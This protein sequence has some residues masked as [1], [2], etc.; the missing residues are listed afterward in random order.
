MKGLTKG[1]RNKWAVLLIVPLIWLLI[2]LLLRSKPVLTPQLIAHRGGGGLAPENTL[3]ALRAGLAAGAH[4]IEVDVQR[5]VDG[6]IVL[7]HDATVDET[8]NGRG[9]VADLTWAEL[10][11]L[12][13]G[14]HFSSEFAGEA[15]PR[16]EDALGLLTAEPVTLMIEVKDP[17]LYPGL[18]SD[19]WDVIRRAGA[20]DRVMVISFAHNWIIG[21]H[22]LAPEVPIGILSYWP[23]QVPGV[24]HG[25][26]ISVL[27]SSV[28]LDPTLVSRVHE[29]G[30]SIV[31]FTVNNPT[32]MRCLL[33]LGIDGVITDRPDLWPQ[34][35][36]E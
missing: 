33:W 8:T 21:F 16:L 30:A 3:A 11:Q 14:S 18:A 35:F 13:A 2:H 5:S 6:V 7:M 9:R 4:V 36:K 27:W 34:A 28:L 10:N 19:L 24:A 1:L 25:Q 12:D 32:L 20:Q 23:Y 31:V 26:A 22:Q 15:V 29:A 17:E